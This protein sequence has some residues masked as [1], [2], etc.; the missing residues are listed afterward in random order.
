MNGQS[1]EVI[2][3]QSSTNDHLSSRDARVLVRHYLQ[4]LAFGRAGEDEIF[5]LF[6]VNRSRYVLLVHQAVGLL[7]SAL[8]VVRTLRRL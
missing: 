8:S 7:G 1:T 2:D 6:G 4:W 5:V 3:R